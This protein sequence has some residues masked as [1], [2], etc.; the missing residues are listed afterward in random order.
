M[1]NVP[2]CIIQKRWNRTNLVRPL[3]VVLYYL[4]LIFFLPRYY[5]SNPNLYP[6]G[7]E[8]DIIDD[9]FD[10]NQETVEIDFATTL[11]GRCRTLETY[12][13]S[14]DSNPGILNVEKG[15]ELHI[16]QR[17]LGSGYTCVQSKHG[18]GFVP[19]SKLYFF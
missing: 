2:G 5:K 14:Q 11:N 18:T 17:D 9:D 7:L 6:L 4:I 10:E 16:I 12:N 3:T 8:Q 15:E 1:D 19:T 13:S